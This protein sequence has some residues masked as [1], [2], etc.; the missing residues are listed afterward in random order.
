MARTAS[1]QFRFLSPAEAQEY[2][3]SCKRSGNY[4]AENYGDRV[5]AQRRVQLPDPPA[6]TLEEFARKYP[7]G[8]TY[9]NPFTRG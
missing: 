8:R 4:S 5:M 3:D 2:L 6:M 1:M 7:P 9:P